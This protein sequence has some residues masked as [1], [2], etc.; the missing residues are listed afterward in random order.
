[1]I[2]VLLRYL[3]VA[4]L[5]AAYGLLLGA[6]RLLGDTHALPLIFTLPLVMAA[7]GGEIWMRAGF[8]GITSATL[9]LLALIALAAL[10][11][12]N[13]VDISEAPAIIALLYEIAFAAACLWLLAAQAAFTYRAFPKRSRD[14]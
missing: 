10:A 2:I 5:G 7:F 12:L 14:A 8:P 13:A 9:H 11:A 1:M 4:R 3:A 6:L